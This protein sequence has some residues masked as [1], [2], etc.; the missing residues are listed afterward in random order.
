MLT[1][2]RRIALLDMLVAAALCLA[3]QVEIWAPRAMVG[4]GTIDGSRPLLSVTAVVGT[5]ALAIRRAAPLVCALLVFGAWGTQGAITTPTQGLTGLIALTL[6]A[7]AVASHAAVGKAAV[8]GAAAIAAIG[9]LATDLADFAFAFAFVA[10]S[11]SVGFAAR[12]RRRQVRSLE[13]ERDGAVERERARIARELHDVVAHRVMTSVVQAQAAR[14]QLDDQLA[15]ERALVDIEEGG[16]AALL[17]LR[18]LLGLLRGEDD[19]GLAPQPSLDQL[20]ALVEEARGAGVP[21][22]LHTEGTPRALATGVSLAAYRIVQEALTNVVKHARSAP[23]TVLVR[24]DDA[25]LTLRIEDA[26]PGG[27]AN[28]RT[29]HGLIGMRERAALYNGTLTTRAAEQTGFVVE[30]VLPIGTA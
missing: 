16:R 25:A 10:A 30:A 12:L 8:G 22:T 1:I 28:G 18:A 20:P 19:N 13:R 27:S 17:E 26:G 23:T 4:V 24:Y 3:A 6:A 21:V 7:Y 5:A 9:A 2:G 15:V 29:G 14:A 11:W